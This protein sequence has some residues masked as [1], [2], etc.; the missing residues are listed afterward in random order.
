MWNGSITVTAVGSS[1]TV[2]VLKPVKPSVATTSTASRHSV[3][4]AASHAANAALERP[5]TMSSSRAGPVLSA[6]GVRSMITVTYLSPARV[7]RRTCSSTP[8]TRT[9]SNLVGS[10]MSTRRPSA[11]TALFGPAPV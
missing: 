6:T 4:L 1:S 11:S 2:A 3:G 8:R 9:P 7:C 10:E 5:L